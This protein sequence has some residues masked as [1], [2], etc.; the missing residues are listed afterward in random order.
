MTSLLFATNNRHKI[1]EMQAAIGHLLNIV[2][3]SEAGI[4]IDIEEP[5]ATLEEN[6]RIKT[7]TIHRMTGM[8][9]F[10]EDTGLEVVAL[11]GAPGVKSA[12]Y[13]GE[14]RNPADN[15]AKLLVELK[16]ISNRAAC[17]RTVISLIWQEK[18]YQFEGRCEGTI[19]EKPRGSDGFGYDPVFLPSGSKLTFAEMSMEQKNRFSHRKKA[20][21]GLVLFL[22][23][24]LNPSGF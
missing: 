3:L 5:Y 2:S 20:A 12:R 10:G 13:A 16:G 1:V 23:Q 6:A 7:V 21:D 15:I 9:C 18:E 11:D 14:D 4:A 8:N 19:I 17:F 24:T 22:Q